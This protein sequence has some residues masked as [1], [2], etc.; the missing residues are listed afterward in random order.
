M[1]KKCV[2]GHLCRHCWEWKK[3]Q[4]MKISTRIWKENI[5]ESIESKAS[6]TWRI[7]LVKTHSKM[8]NLYTGKR[9]KNMIAL[10]VEKSH[11]WFCRCWDFI[12]SV[13]H[14]NICQHVYTTM[15]CFRSFGVWRR[16]RGTEI[17]REWERVLPTARLS[18]VRTCCL[19]PTYYNTCSSSSDAALKSIVVSKH[20][21]MF[22]S[23]W[24]YYKCNAK[25]KL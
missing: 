16:G 12:F 5:F 24:R 20:R 1:K 22:T 23:S 14:M 10:N 2:Q 7:I 15:N 21:L 17:K 18:Y 8:K 19:D 4:N 11:F 25:M 9:D 6:F 13:R 3:K